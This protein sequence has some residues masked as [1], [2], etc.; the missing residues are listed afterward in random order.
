M[1]PKKQPER[2]TSSQKQATQDQD[3][4]LLLNNYPNNYPDKEQENEKFSRADEM[5][6]SRNVNP[7]LLQ[8]RAALIAAAAEKTATEFLTEKKDSSDS[9]FQNFRASFAKNL[10]E[11]SIKKSGFFR[12]SEKKLSEDAAEAILR[13]V[14][15]SQEL[16]DY[17]FSLQPEDFDLT[18]EVLDC[19][20]G[21]YF[22]NRWVEEHPRAISRSL[23]AQKAAVNTLITEKHSLPRKS[24]EQEQVSWEWMES[25]LLGKAKTR[26][27]NRVVPVPCDPADGRTMK[28]LTALSS[29]IDGNLNKDSGLLRLFVTN[30]DVLRYLR[31]IF[32][33]PRRKKRPGEKI[34]EKD[35]ETIDL[36][37][38]AGKEFKKE[39]V[40]GIL[41]LA[42]DVVND[43]SGNK[44][45]FLKHYGGEPELT[46]DFDLLVYPP[47]LPGDPL[48]SSGEEQMLLR[49]DLDVVESK[50]NVPYL[51]EPN[52][53]NLDTD[54]PVESKP[55]LRTCPSRT[56]TAL[57]SPKRKPYPL[58]RFSRATNMDS[59]DHKFRVQS[60]SEKRTVPQSCCAPKTGSSALVPL[61]AIVGV[62][63]MRTQAL[64]GRT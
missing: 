42:I 35:N 54:V 12:S 45:F 38:E 36:S 8:D 27:G 29:A 50:P 25:N 9:A 26:D 24:A 28:F 48:D 51:F 21:A 23:N 14:D 10:K 20:L 16:F 52:L 57:T 63:L 59:D 62:R 31:K 32:Y 41:D 22:A 56:S 3:T 55:N 1:P 19:G 7:V 15:K 13:R 4:E 39:L 49:D 17:L 61:A 34:S 40:K 43:P 5:L 33:A 44:R 53:P 11:I 2:Y 37:D 46:D 6:K 64:R 18:Q 58:L 30:R 60:K 47:I